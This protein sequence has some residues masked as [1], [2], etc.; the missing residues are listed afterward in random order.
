M[1]PRRDKIAATKTIPKTKVPENVAKLRKNTLTAIMESDK[2]NFS[3][4]HRITA[5]QYPQ[6]SRGGYPWSAKNHQ[7]ANHDLYA[8][9]LANQHSPCDYP[10]E[11]GMITTYSA[12]N[13]CLLQT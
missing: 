9:H 12:T 11:K 1:I 2:S 13:F 8:F 4:G 10:E 3:A 5:R 6:N 7:L